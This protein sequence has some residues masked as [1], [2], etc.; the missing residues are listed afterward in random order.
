M[1]PE[2]RSTTR[3]MPK[4]NGTQITPV[5]VIEHDGGLW[6]ADRHAAGDRA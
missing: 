3:R 4:I 1:E 2:R 5:A 6:A